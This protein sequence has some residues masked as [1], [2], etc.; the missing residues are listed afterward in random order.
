[1]YLSFILWSQHYTPQMSRKATRHN[2]W[3]EHQLNHQTHTHLENHIEYFILQQQYPFY[4]VE[5]ASDELFFLHVFSH[6]PISTFLQL[7]C[8][9]HWPFPILAKC[10]LIKTV[11]VSFLLLASLE[12]SI[13]CVG[14]QFSLEEV[15]TF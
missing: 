6:L 5:S 11:Q 9:S 13:V 4:P 15:V 10:F 7:M 1:M 12:F 14:S 8:C 2:P 3:T